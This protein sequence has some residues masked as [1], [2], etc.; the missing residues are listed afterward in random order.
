[1]A[2][3]LAGEYEIYAVCPGCI[4]GAAQVSV[5][6][7]PYL[8]NLTPH[9]SYQ[10]VGQTSSHPNAWFGTVG[11]VAKLQQ[12]CI[13]FYNET[14][15]QVGVNDMSLPWGGLFDIGPPYGSFWNPP[16]YEH[17]WGRNADIPFR[18]L[19]AYRTI[20][21]SIA[22]FHQVQVYDQGDHYHLRFPN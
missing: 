20:F 9:Y 7:Y 19:G 1:V 16:H 11:T 22:S 15:L 2:E 4:S 14:G 8:Q 12:I 18:Y 6:V 21:T 10:R 5:L 13:Q 3:Q 17:R